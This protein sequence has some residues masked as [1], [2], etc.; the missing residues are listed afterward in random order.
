MANWEDEPQEA[1]PAR[2]FFEDKF[3]PKPDPGVAPFVRPPIVKQEQ[4]NAPMI[5]GEP[6]PLPPIRQVPAWNE[7]MLTELDAAIDQAENLA[8]GPVVVTT[9]FDPLM[10]ID[11]KSNKNA[12]QRT[13]FTKNMFQF[14]PKLRWLPG[15]FHVFRKNPVENQQAIETFCQSAASF[16]IVSLM[17]YAEAEP[18]YRVVLFTLSTPLITILFDLRSWA[19]QRIVMPDVIMRVIGNPNV[20]VVCPGMNDWYYGS[21][22]NHLSMLRDVVSPL[23]QMKIRYVQ[24]FATTLHINRSGKDVCEHMKMIYWL[25][26]VKI[27]V[28][29]HGGAIRWAV[30][31]SEWRQFTD[32]YG[33]LLIY[34]YWGLCKKQKLF[35]KNPKPGL[36][37]SPIYLEDLILEKRLYDT[38]DKAKL[39]EMLIGKARYPDPPLPDLAVPSR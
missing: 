30:I 5:H 36:D 32:V 16:R 26:Q 24:D 34:L 19:H 13:I 12:K 4:L 22:N 35:D 37:M 25:F 28:Q 39:R 3:D 31:P 21:N 14:E 8:D 29:F 10:R 33:K 1:P 18:I 6:P 20:V 38:D 2:P 11:K 15:E 9:D 7:R 17:I 23:P 27:D